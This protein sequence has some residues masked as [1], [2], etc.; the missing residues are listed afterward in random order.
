MANYVKAIEFDSPFH[1][2]QVIY[3]SSLVNVFLQS[4]QAVSHV[5]RSIELEFQKNQTALD[6]KVTLAIYKHNFTS[7]AQAPLVQVIYDKLDHSNPT[8]VQCCLNI[9]L[10]G[11]EKGWIQFTSVLNGLLNVMPT[12]R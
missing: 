7:S 6:I 12:T 5:M 11:T 4:L 2:K 9:L 8:V 10:S 1:Q 3:L